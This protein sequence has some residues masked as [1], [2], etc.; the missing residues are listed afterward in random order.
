MEWS[1]VDIKPAFILWLEKPV[2]SIINFQW[3]FFNIW[4]Y[5][6]ALFLELFDHFSLNFILVLKTSCA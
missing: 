2:G 1:F 5:F 3:I 4:R 6:Q